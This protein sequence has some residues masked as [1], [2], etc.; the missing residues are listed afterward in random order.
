VNKRFWLHGNAP[1]KESSF[2]HS[3]TWK[4][5]TGAQIEADAFPFQLPSAVVVAI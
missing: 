4:E 1:G 2:F 3:E 5:I